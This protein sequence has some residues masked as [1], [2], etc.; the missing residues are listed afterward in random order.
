MTATAAQAEPNGTLTTF[1]AAAIGTTVTGEQ[2]GEHTYVFTDHP[3]PSAVHCKKSHFD[4][5]GTV[6]NGSTTVT[7]TPTYSECKAFGLNAAIDH[8]EC[9]YI[10]HF[11]TKLP[12]GGW[13]ATTTT[14]CP[15]GKALAITAAT[16]EVI[17]HPQELPNTSEVTNSGPSVPETGMGL[18]LHTNIAELK[19]T[20]TK[21]GIGCPLSGIGSF[22]KGHYFGTTTFKGHDFGKNP[23][24]ITLH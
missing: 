12:L 24:G 2:I 20:V 16:C 1:P 14:S 6:A 8:N 15:T 5:V 7:V 23:V 21:D 11:K 22:S 17:I 9:T 10:L 19:Y 13:D 3:G 18:H 4:G